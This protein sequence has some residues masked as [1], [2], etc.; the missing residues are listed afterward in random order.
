MPGTSKDLIGEGHGQ[1]TEKAAAKAFGGGNAALAL[2]CQS[3]TFTLTF[4][5]LWSVLARA[6]YA[7]NVESI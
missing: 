7:A 3:L 5:Q 4:A 1:L 2:E 6:I